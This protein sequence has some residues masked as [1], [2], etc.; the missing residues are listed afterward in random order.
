MPVQ[1]VAARVIRLG[2]GN[3]TAQD[4]NMVETSAKEIKF[5]QDNAGR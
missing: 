5:K 4:P 2:D 1:S 3:V